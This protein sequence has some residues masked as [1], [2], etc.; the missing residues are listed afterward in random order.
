MMSIFDDRC[1]NRRLIRQ[2]QHDRGRIPPAP[3][4]R[5]GALI[6]VAENIFFFVRLLYDEVTF[7]ISSA[8]GGTMRRRIVQMAWGLFA[9]SLVA[10]WH[11]RHAAGNRRPLTRRIC[12]QQDQRSRVSALMG[13]STLLWDLRRSWGFSSWADPTA[14]FQAVAPSGLQRMASRSW[15][16][17]TSRPSEHRNTWT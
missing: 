10:G 5:R 15:L 12:K 6:S 9:L 1:R 2:L 7:K 16:W 14:A 11:T 3:P 8:S 13:N 4:C 17:H